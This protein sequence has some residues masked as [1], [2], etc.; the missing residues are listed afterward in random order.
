LEQA[1][2]NG[3]AALQIGAIAALLT[4]PPA[5]NAQTGDA[6]ATVAFIRHGEKPPAGL[7]QL[8]CQGLN[9]ALALPAVLERMFGKPDAI[10]APDPSGKNDDGGIAFDYVRPLAT[11]EP[12]AIAFGLPVNASIRFTQRRALNAALEKALTKGG[13]KFV[14]VAWEHKVIAPS[15]KALLAAHGGDPAAVPDW[16]GTDFDSMYVVTLGANGGKANF[17]IKHEGLDGQP[18]TCPQ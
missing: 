16:N 1:F 12:A 4:V 9:R 14:L 13:A 7:G 5:G 17:E 10:F 2:R 18:K 15:V 6:A 8:D 3:M 11:V